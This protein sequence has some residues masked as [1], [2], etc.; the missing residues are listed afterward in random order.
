M[1][2]VAEMGDARIN[3]QLGDAILERAYWRLRQHQYDPSLR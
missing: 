1:Q 2:D 3:G